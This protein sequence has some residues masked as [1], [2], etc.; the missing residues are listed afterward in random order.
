MSRTSKSPLERL[1]LEALGLGAD[2]L[3]VEYRDGHEEVVAM[4]GSIGAAIARFASGSRRL[5][6]MGSWCALRA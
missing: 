2:A 1:V 5:T 4:G 6:A 3:E